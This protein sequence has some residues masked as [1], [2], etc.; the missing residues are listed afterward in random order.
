MRKFIRLRHPSSEGLWD[1]K[2][3]GE[4]FISGSGAFCEVRGDTM[5]NLSTYKCSFALKINDKVPGLFKIN[6]DIDEYTQV[7][8]EQMA[9][10]AK[11]RRKSIFLY[12]DTEPE[13]D[14]NTHQRLERKFLDI[15]PGGTLDGTSLMSFSNVNGKDKYIIADRFRGSLWNFLDAGK[16]VDLELVVLTQFIVYF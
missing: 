2:S 5:I 14:L 7:F 13:V 16:S 10:H 9:P 8:E 12:D 4:S 11:V 3:Y 1:L 15:Y 6:S